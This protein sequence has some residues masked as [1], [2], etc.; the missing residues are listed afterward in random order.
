VKNDAS[1]E[2][3]RRYGDYVLMATAYMDEV[4][5]EGQGC[6]LRDVDGNE[7]LDFISGQIC[8]TLGHNHP[9]LV[10]RLEK[11]LRR[12]IHTSTSFLSPVVFEAAAKFAEIMPGELRKTVFLSTGAEANEYAVRLAK[13]YT[14]KTGVLC[15][16][17]GYAGLT[18]QTASLTNYGRAARP[19]VP[20][21]GYLLTPD[22][23]RCPAGTA[24]EDWARELLDVS[25]ELNRG[26]LDNVAA[27]IFEPILSAGGLVVLPDD[28][29]RRLRRLADDLGAMLIADEAQT[30]MGRTGRWYCVEHAGVTPDFMVSS[31]GVGGGMPLSA[32]TTTPAIAAEVLGRANQYS[33]HQSDALAA[34]A[35]LAVIEVIEAEGL[36]QNARDMG[37][38]MMEGLRSLAASHSRLTH[39]RGRGLMIGF[40]IAGDAEGSPGGTEAASAVQSYCRSRG[41]ITQFVQQGRFRVLPPLIV[42][43][44][45][46]DR[47]I[48]VLDE[49]LAAL[50][51]GTIRPRPPSNEYSAAFAARRATG[52]KA[53]MQWAWSNSPELWLAKIRGRM[54]G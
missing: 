12:L 7:Y 14:G 51:R 40:D 16:C 20:G 2:L 41:I 47:Y 52:I 45:H 10:E 38:Y 33:S 37:E 5:S 48:A 3:W 36:I 49:A 27:I 19:I 28:Y 43:K 29:M 53:A 31:K 35:G 39:V 15:L 11:Q 17:K 13:A 1:L 9:A 32:V 46:I 4:L 42:Q 22:P 26:L 6:V 25:L 23:T 24:P 44:P 21:T 54:K 30:G 50:A 18:L 8:A 34:A